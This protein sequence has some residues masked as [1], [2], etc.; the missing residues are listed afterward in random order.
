MPALN[1]LV[2]QNS[3]R[4]DVL[5]VSLAT[6]KVDEL[7]A[8]LVRTP[9]RHETVADSQGYIDTPGVRA[10]PTHFIVNREGVVTMVGNDWDG[11]EEA[12]REA[13]AG[14]AAAPRP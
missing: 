11:M 3:G 10:Y 13:T 8:F 14:A 6:D 4:K 7:A 5:F 1:A 12:F 2:A 9:F